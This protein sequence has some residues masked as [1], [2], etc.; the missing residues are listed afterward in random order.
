MSTP[1]AGLRVSDNDFA[2]LATAFGTGA[3]GAQAQDITNGGTADLVVM[4]DF[5]YTEPVPQ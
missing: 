4:D 1:G 5:L 3:L 2:D